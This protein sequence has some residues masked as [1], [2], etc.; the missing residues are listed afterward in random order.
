MVVNRLTVRHRGQWAVTHTTETLPVIYL[1]TLIMVSV[2]SLTIQ[3]SMLCLTIVYSRLE[4]MLP[5]FQNPTIKLFDFDFGLK[6]Q[7]I[8]KSDKR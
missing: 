1:Y 4:L 3:L 6:F 7:E 5:C 2:A 8:Y